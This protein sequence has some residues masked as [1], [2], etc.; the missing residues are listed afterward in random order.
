MNAIRLL[1]KIQADPALARI[2]VV[3]AL[4]TP[5]P[6]VHRERSPP[7]HWCLLSLR[8]PPTTSCTAVYSGQ[9]DRNSVYRCLQAGAVDYMIKPL[10]Q[11]E[12]S[13]AALSG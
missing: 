6:L 9:D 1:T 12:A 7:R 10:R 4:P 8:N 2:P 5:S 3:G 13:G 11:N